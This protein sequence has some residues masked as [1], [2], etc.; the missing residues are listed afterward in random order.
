MND[1]IVLELARLE[2]T[3]LHRL[4]QRM[5]AQQL[6]EAWVGI[7][8]ADATDK[9]HERDDIGAGGSLL[10]HL[11]PDGAKPPQRQ[12]DTTTEQATA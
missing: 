8:S 9:Q 1:E 10:D 11:A 3:A 5:Q 4:R 12:A 6:G 2:R 7:W